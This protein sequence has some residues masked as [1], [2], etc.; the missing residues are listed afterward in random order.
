VPSGD[1]A[2]LAAGLGDLVAQV[3]AGLDVEDAQDAALVAGLGDAVGDEPSVQ[4]RVVPVDGR[5][6][7]GGQRGRIDQEARRGR[8]LVDRPD[9]ERQLLLAASPLQREHAITGQADASRDRQL[10]QA[11]EAGQPRPAVGAGIERGPGAF[12][13]G[14][15]P[16]D[17]LGRVTVLEPSVGVRHH[18]AV[19]HVR[20]RLPPRRRRRSQHGSVNAPCWDACR[21][22][23][24]IGAC[25]PFSSWSSS[26]WGTRLAAGQAACTQRSR[27]S[28]GQVLIT[29]STGTALCAALSQPCGCHSSC[30]VAWA[31]ESIEMKQP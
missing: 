22:W 13:L 17:D 2:T 16:R 28:T 24:W 18:P 21:G 19:Q 4:R 5:R 10:E 1:H 27:S 8:W 20:R 31:S 25:A 14:R 11:D 12:V 26:T 29:R 9:H 3:L 15:D 7:V 6:R 23:P 30:P